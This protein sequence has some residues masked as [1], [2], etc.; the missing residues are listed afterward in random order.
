MVYRKAWEVAYQRDRA[1]GRARYVDAEP[2]RARLAELAAAHVPIRALAR[3]AALSDTGVKAILDG[4]RTHV[5]QLT[6]A[7]V[8]KTS[9]RG[10]Y[11]EQHSGHVPRAGAVRRVQALM[12]MGWS[13]QE[14]DRAGV[15]NTARLL[16]GTGNLVTI[17]RWREISELYDR[18]SMTPGPSP[19]TRGWAKTLG[20]APPL[21]WDEDTIDDPR[22]QPHGKDEEHSPGQV[23]DMVAIRRT[24]DEP[25]TNAALT[26][27]EQVI[28]MRAMA[29]RGRSDAHIGER[30]GV[31]DRTVLRWRHRDGIP[32]Q[33][34]DSDLD[35]SVAAAATRGSPPAPGSPSHTANLETRHGLA[36]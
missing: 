6:A 25:G 5:Q 36:R 12:A 10:I 14:L 24:L 9:L 11:A 15:P 21:A 18:L 13:H 4:S 31:S 26:P 17:Q 23:I 30:L 33:T 3:A 2:T 8:A 27:Q 32:A 19:Q 29:A 16:T 35:W 34:P 20:Y 7:R 22:A 28:A 1:A